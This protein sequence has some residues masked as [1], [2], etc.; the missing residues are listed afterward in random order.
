MRVLH[1][2]RAPVGGLFRHVCDLVV[3]Q[4]RLGLKVGVVCDDS[5]SDEH[6]S[7]RLAQLRDFCELGVNQFPMRR[8]PH[9]SD[10]RVLA[11]VLRAC[12][13]AR[14]DL[15]HGHG[16]K[17]GAYG[18]LAA[19]CL[20]ARAVYAPHGG[21]LHFDPLTVAGW[22]YLRLER[23][24]RRYTHG[25]LFECQSSAESFASKVGSLA[26]PQRVVYNG[27]SERDLTPVCPAREQYDFLFIGELR[28]LKGIH[29][30]LESMAIL[31]RRRSARL[32]IVGG[33]PEEATIRSRVESSGLVDLV[34]VAPPVHPARS[35]FADARCVVVPSLAEGF[36]YVVLEALGAGLPVVTTRVGGIPEMFG[37]HACHLVAPDDSEALAAAMAG[38]LDDPAQA[39]RDG[40]CLRDRVRASFRLD[41]MVDAIVDF[42]SRLPPVS[43]A[44]ADRCAS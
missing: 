37:P 30:L 27:L 42:Y 10:A 36:P 18:R 28:A 26:C 33:G 9:Y 20:G 44:S 39:G 17:G 2:L 3:G 5:T 23:F 29:V 4:S 16:A 24:L 6:A 38:F 25:V 35:A 15:I 11:D 43:S 22:T 40:Q 31:A 13:K 19:R 12:S 8:R 7:S 34:D 41:S 32:L 1:Y 21:S 14:P